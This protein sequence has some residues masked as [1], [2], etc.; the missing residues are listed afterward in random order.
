MDGRCPNRPRCPGPDG[1]VLTSL[2][3]S[4][5][6]MAPR[7]HETDVIFVGTSQRCCFGMFIDLVT[8]T[9]VQFPP[10]RSFPL[11]VHGEAIF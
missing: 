3:A 6:Q 2:P 8:A 1:M 5:G 11:H 4:C 10:Q 9:P 7:R